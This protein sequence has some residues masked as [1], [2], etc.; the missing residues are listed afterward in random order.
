M[1]H[2]RSVTRMNFLDGLRALAALYVVAHHVT[3]IY[4]PL[5]KQRPMAPFVWEA[6]LVLMWGRFAV[7]TFIVISGFCLTLPY[8]QAAQIHV[9]L[10]GF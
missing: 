10:K 8:A 2:I 3:L 5:W 6:A 4:W 9:D 7:S 1:T